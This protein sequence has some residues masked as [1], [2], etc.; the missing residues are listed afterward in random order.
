MQK[1]WLAGLLY[2]VAFTVCFVAFAVHMFRVI[3]AFYSI[4]LDFDNAA[5][6]E[7]LRIRGA[8]FSLVAALAV[9]A[10]A[11]ADVYAA[12]RRACAAWARRKL[13]QG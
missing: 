12:Y 6:P 11:L 7:N 4:G 2:G 13:P 10:A 5:P 3:A 1:R 8:L 9:Y